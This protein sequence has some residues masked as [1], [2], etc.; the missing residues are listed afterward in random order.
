M[1]T[2]L[3]TG[4][5]IVTKNA[6]EPHPLV[7]YASYFLYGFSAVVAGDTLLVLD[8]IPLRVD[9]RCHDE[10]HICFEYD[11]YAVFDFSE[12]YHLERSYYRSSS[13][14]RSCD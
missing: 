3:T 11:L 8:G 12:E 2:L 7:A 6:L 4:T 14:F 13:C 1:F 10:D 5:L 9:V